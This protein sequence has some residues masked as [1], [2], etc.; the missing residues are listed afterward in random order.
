MS[1]TQTWGIREINSPYVLTEFTNRLDAL[2]WGKQREWLLRYE[3]VSIIREETV[4]VHETVDN[5]GGA[6]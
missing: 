4:R 1:R 5:V 2:A 6:S 3:L